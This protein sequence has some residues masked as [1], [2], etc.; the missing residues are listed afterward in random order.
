MRPHFGLAVRIRVRHRHVRVA[1]RVLLRACLLAFG[2]RSGSSERR[3]RQRGGG[4]GGAR[5]WGKGLYLGHIGL[6][7]LVLAVALC[8]CLHEIGA[9]GGVGTSI[10][11]G[12]IGAVQVCACG[13]RRVVSVH[14]WRLRASA[15]VAARAFEPG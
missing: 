1:H 2:G 15:A 10:V 13:T 8:A 3:R 9:F 5:G 14:P 6:H 4:G 11:K 7:H 12:A